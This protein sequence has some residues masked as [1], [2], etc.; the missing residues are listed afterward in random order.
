MR[1]WDWKAI[2]PLPRH[3]AQY[4]VGNIERKSVRTVH[5]FVRQ[6]VN[7]TKRYLRVACHK[8]EVRGVPLAIISTEKKRAYRE[9]TFSTHPHTHTHNS[10]QVT[11]CACAIRGG[12]L[13][14]LAKTQVVGSYSRGCR[15]S[16][17]REIEIDGAT[18]RHTVSYEQKEAMGRKP[19]PKRPTKSYLISSNGTP[20]LQYT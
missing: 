8:Y 15:R 2:R 12:P 14:P 1:R 9:S 3:R 6:V 19:E 16:E 18:R 7:I 10:K 13:L 11:T 4:T 20:T 5:A 17:Y